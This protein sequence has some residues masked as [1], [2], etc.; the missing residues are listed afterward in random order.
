MKIFSQSLLLVAL[1][2]FLVLAQEWSTP[3]QISERE[4]RVGHIPQILAIGDTIHVVYDGFFSTSDHV[5]YIK[6][7]DTGITWSNPIILSSDSSSAILPHILRC[8]SELMCIWDNTFNDGTPWM[9]RAN[10]CYRTSSDNGQSWSRQANVLNPGWDGYYWYASSCADSVVNISIELGI[11]C[12]SMFIYNV[13]STNFGRTWSAPRQIFNA[14]ETTGSCDQVSFGNYVHFVWS[15]SFERDS[16]PTLNYTRSSDG[17]L[18]WSD[19][20]VL[21]TR[22]WRQIPSISVNQSGMLGILW[23]QDDNV[24]LRL[25]YDSGENWDSLIQVTPIQVSIDLGDI[26]FD[27]GRIIIAW[28]NDYENKLFINKSYDEGQSWDEPYWLDRDSFYYDSW[29]PALAS[30]K[31]RIYA[32]WYNEGSDRDSFTTTGVYFSYWPYYEDAVDDDQD[33]LPSAI[34]LSAYPNPFNSSAI[35]SLNNMADAEISIYDIT[36]RLVETLKADKGQ[37]VW[38]ASG[39]SSGVYFARV[40]DSGLSKS[41][42]LVLLK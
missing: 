6:S 4:R 32:A 3:I 33:N 8:G 17:G 10:I 23:T 9:R 11:C 27:Y 7:T 21:N 28:P 12:D 26:V 16:F 25:S 29:S 31:D 2:A 37:S 40:Q 1:M 39:V 24:F 15:S 22:R 36:G 13:R 20:V 41:I 14:Y 34:S 42:K 18:T 38:D 19:Y 30:A 5:E 35:L